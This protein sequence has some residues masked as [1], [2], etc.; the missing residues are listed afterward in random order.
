LVTIQDHSVA[1]T[2]DWN[3]ETHTVTET[4]AWAMVKSAPGTE[5]FANA[6]NAATAPMRF[7]FRWREDL[8]RLTGKIVMDGRSYDVKSVEEVGRREL[9]QVLAVAQVDD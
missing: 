7:F 2:N 9:L 4:Q 5:R 1:S 8:V 3:E 6:E